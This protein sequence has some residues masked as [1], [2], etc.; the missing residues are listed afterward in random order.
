MLRRNGK[1]VSHSNQPHVYIPKHTN[2]LL[3][4]LM[5]HGTDC[6]T[7]AS[8]FLSQSGFQ[9]LLYT[10][11]ICQTDTHT[12]IHTHSFMHICT[13][14][15]NQ[16]HV[17]QDTHEVNFYCPDL[18]HTHTHFTPTSVVF[19]LLCKF[20]IQH[21]LSPGTVTENRRRLLNIHMSFISKLS[22]QLNVWC[23]KVC[24]NRAFWFCTWNTNTVLLTRFPALHKCFI[25]HG[26]WDWSI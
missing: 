17:Q 6:W 1:R 11:C 14:N 19:S 21:P 26:Q 3:W 24:G 25:K 20:W 10:S 4:A 22:Q 16:S 2:N 7:S 8:L 15:N 18:T 9:W 5:S 13:N 23:E 12:N